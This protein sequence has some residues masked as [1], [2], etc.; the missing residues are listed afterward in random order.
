LERLISEDRHQSPGD[1]INLTNTGPAD[2]LTRGDFLDAAIEALESL[3]RHRLH[4]ILSDA[5]VEMSGPEFRNR[6]IIPLLSTIGARWQEG[7][8]RIVH[9]HMAS[10]IVRSFLGAPRN[11]ADRAR[12]P[13]MIITTPAGQYHELGALMASAVAE[14][15]GWD[16]FYLGTSLPAEE[17]AAAARQ[18]KAQAIALSLCYRENDS[19]VLEELTR[20]RH[21]VDDDVP[22]FVGGNAVRPLR[23]RLL[24][25]GVMC[26]A[27]LAEFRSALQSSLT[28]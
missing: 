9:E 17:I 12:A 14:E 16:V 28:V 23:D 8:L 22:V 13:R 19:H 10:I 15:M 7:S 21:L 20:L 3:D 6:L 5:S 11:L 27:D 24:E 2:E 4:R 25:A 18:I 26:P 1:S